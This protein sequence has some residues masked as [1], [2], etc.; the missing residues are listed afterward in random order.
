MRR[1]LA[2]GTP[3]EEAGALLVASSGPCPHAVM[4]AATSTMVLGF[5]GKKIAG[6]RGGGAG[7]GMREILAAAEPN[8]SGRHGLGSLLPRCP[9]APLLKRRPQTERPQRAHAPAVQ[10][11]GYVHMR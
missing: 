8:E 3:F 9:A 5:T 6:Q 10:R 4:H 7:G 1:T 11:K 2:P